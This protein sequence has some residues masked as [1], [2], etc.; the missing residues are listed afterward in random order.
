MCLGGQGLH[1]QTAL[2]GSEA[3]EIINNHPVELVI[4]DI[5]MPNIDG[6]QLLKLVKEQDDTIQ[7]IVMTGY[8]D[9]KNTEELIDKYDAAGYLTKPFEDIDQL[10]EAINY[11]FLKRDQAL[12]R[13]ENTSLTNDNRP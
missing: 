13:S 9:V 11:A 12:G 1:V 6:L 8:T 10:L 2:N 4:T 3:L 7:V 5:R